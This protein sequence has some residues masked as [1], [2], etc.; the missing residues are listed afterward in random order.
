MNPIEGYADYDAIGLS[1]L[2]K[3]KQVSPS[4]L[5]ET[6]IY[7]IEQLNPALNAVIYPFYDEAR[8]VARGHLPDA[9]FKGVPFLIK[10][11][12]TTYSGTPYSKGCNA[13]KKNVSKNDSGLMLSYKAAGL[14]TLGKTNTPEFGLYAYTEPSAFGAT[15]NP[16]NPDYIT[17]GSSGGS[18]AAVASGMVPVASGGDGGGSIRIPA[19]CC[20]LFGLKPSRGRTPTAPHTEIWQGAVVEHILS[21]SVRDSAA[22]LDAIMA[23]DGFSKHFNKKETSYLDATKIPPNRLNIAFTTQ[24]PLGTKVD[25]DCIGAVEKAVNLLKNLGHH[26]EEAKPEYD[27]NSLA[28]AFMMM[29]FQETANEIND[30]KKIIGRNLVKGDI[31]PLTFTFGLLGKAYHAE[32]FA[33]YK[34]LWSQTEL[35]MEQFHKRYDLFLTPTLAVVPP[36]AGELKASPG[37]QILMDTVNYFSLGKL[38]KISGLVDKLIIKSFSKMPYTQMPNLTGQPAMS[39]PL[40][41]THDQIPIGVQFIAAKGN[42]ILLFKLASQ[43]ENIEPWFNK[44]PSLFAGK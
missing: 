15:V 27:G 2:V 29:C 31:E 16:W 36:L 39:V 18:A 42:E 5:V 30:L 44:H 3:S 1:K 37:Q 21:R 43:L 25:P 38:L 10:D 33:K 13:L 23:G 35:V 19:S 20:G 7:F 14:I 12:I 32:E 40:Y 22:M 24:S 34:N 4:E 17:G 9:V 11:W 41:W 26:V 6:A 28:K 8:K